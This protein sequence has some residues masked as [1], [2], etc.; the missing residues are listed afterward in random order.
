MNKTIQ[1]LVQRSKILGVHINCAIQC[2]PMKSQLEIP[3]IISHFGSVQFLPQDL[4]EIF[5]YSAKESRKQVFLFSEIQ[6]IPL[7]DQD[8]LILVDLSGEV[9]IFIK[10]FQ[11]KIIFGQYRHC[12]IGIIRLLLSQCD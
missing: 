12:D 6:Y 2:A 1:Q 7:Y 5:N 9:G 11:S 10:W 8:D 3:Q 4:I